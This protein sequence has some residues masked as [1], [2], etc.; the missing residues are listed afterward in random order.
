MRFPL[1]YAA[2]LALATPG[3]AQAPPAKSPPTGIEIPKNEHDELSA[4]TAALQAEIVALGQPGALTAGLQE[5]LVD[6]EIFSKAVQWA[7]TLEEFYEPKQFAAARKLLEEGH[8]RAKALRAGIAPWTRATGLVV[9]GFRSKI[10]GSVQPYGVFVPEDRPETGGRMDIW[11]HGRNDKLTELAFLSGRM[12]SKGEFTPPKT[13]VLHPYGRF[14]N[15]YKFAGETDVLEAMD[16][17]IAQ[18]GISR[19]HVALRGFSMGGAGSWHLGAHHTRLWSVIAP[20][21]GFVE[22]AEYATVFAPGKEAPHWWEQTLWHLY[23]VPDYVLNLTNRPVI[24]YSGEN[25]PQKRAAD[26]MVAALKGVGCEIEHLIGPNTGHKYHPET[27]AALILKVDEAAEK[28]RPKDPERVRLETYTLRYNTMEWV[29]ITGLEQHWQ[30]ATVDA[31]HHGS[32]QLAVKT[33]GV[34][35]LTLS[36][37]QKWAGAGSWKV[38]LDG[39]ALTSASKTLPLHFH[40]TDGEWRPAT[41]PDDGA[42][43]LRKRSGLQGPIDDAFMSSFVFV[44]PTGKSSNPAV[45]AWA[46]AEL[47]TAIHNWR[48]NFRGEPRVVKDTDVTAELMNSAHL[49]LWGDAESNGILAR[50]LPKLPLQWDRQKL[51]LGGTTYDATKHA[52]VMIYPNP[53][54]PQYYIVLNSSYTFRQGSFNTNALQVP[55]LPDWAVLDLSTPPDMNWAGQVLDAG[56]F[57]EQWQ[58]PKKP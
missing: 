37:P 10:D 8:I 56:F 38:N 42:P 24:A 44:R 21:A 7:L 30:H 33:T 18:Y 32:G 20:G 39:Q 34:A 12:G 57:N 40:K 50:V 25:D 28:G 19:D 35:A 22:T 49:V 54:A 4:A 2:F 16:D 48:V 23:D 53:L 52:P 45:E 55:K 13:L 29:Q 9:R 1:R 14:C 43:P 17:A 11:L 15:A 26:K 46:S 6:V 41:S 36:P 58:F 51:S 31:S 47:E 5:R 27:K 3:F